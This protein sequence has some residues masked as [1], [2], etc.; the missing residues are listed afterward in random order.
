MNPSHKAQISRLNRAIGQLEAVGRMIEQGRYCV[1]I[2]TQLRAARSAVKSIEL[3]ILQTHMG[4]CMS[5]ACASKDEQRKEQSIAEIMEL[6][7]R[8]E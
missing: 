2:L 8:Y 1:D 4:A 6:L 7:K 3:E 5:E